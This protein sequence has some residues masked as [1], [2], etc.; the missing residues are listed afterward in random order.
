[1]KGIGG[2]MGVGLTTPSPRPK[3]GSRRW[4]VALPF[5]QRGRRG[6][7]QVSCGIVRLERAGESGERAEIE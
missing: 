5:L 6:G 7:A 3:A 2:E 4:D 1:M